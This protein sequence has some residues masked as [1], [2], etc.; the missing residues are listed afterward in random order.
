M[1]RRSSHT[2]GELRQMILD[3]SRD[4]LQREGIKGLSARA[5]AKKIGY[6]PGTLYNVFKNLDD[7]LMTIQA[8]TLDDMITSL[9]ALPNG[10]KP[11]DNIRALTGHYIG[12]ALHNRHLWNLLFQHVPEERVTA[13]EQIDE[14]IET[15]IGLLRH[16]IEPLANGSPGCEADKCART[17]W[18][19]IHGISAIAVTEKSASVTPGNG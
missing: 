17:I 19:G 4:I 10:G 13:P 8:M 9:K 14:R 6:S 1:G 11:H 3:A 5:I 15:I 18:A 7:L 16:A 12:Y 2:P